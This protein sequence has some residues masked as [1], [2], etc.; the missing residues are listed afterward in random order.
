MVTGSDAEARLWVLAT[1][2]LARRTER[3]PRRGRVMSSVLRPA[4]AQWGAFVSVDESHAFRR[5]DLDSGAYLGEVP[6]QVEPGAW[7]MAAD[8]TLTRGIFGQGYENMNGRPVLVS[9]ED[10]AP[11][12]VLTDSW[13]GTATFLSDGR[14]VSGTVEWAVY[15]WDPEGRNPEPLVPP[16]PPTEQSETGP[17]P[18]RIHQ[19]VPCAGPPLFAVHYW[20]LISIFDG[21]GRLVREIRDHVTPSAFSR[22][23]K[24]FAS[25]ASSGGRLGVF[26]VAS[27]REVHAINADNRPIEVLAFSADNRRL[28]TADGSGDI[29]VRTLEGPDT[30]AIAFPPADTAN[31][32][33]MAR[34]LAADGRTLLLA[35]EG[36]EVFEW[37]LERRAAPVRIASMG[38]GSLVGTTVHVVE[39][40]VRVVHN[41]ASFMTLTRDGTLLAEGV[42]ADGSLECSPGGSRFAEITTNSV[43]HLDLATGR[44]L[45]EHR[46]APTPLPPLESQSYLPGRALSDGGRVACVDDSR[47][48][49]WE[50]DGRPVSA[51]P[52]ATLGLGP[53][54]YYRCLFLDEDQVAITSLQSGAVVTLSTGNVRAY[55]SGVATMLA[56]DPKRRRLLQSA[57]GE[58]GESI[59]VVRDADDS[60][61]V[62]EIPI[63]SS[64]CTAIFLDDG[65]LVTSHEDRRVIV[66]EIG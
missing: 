34:G 6:L 24:R 46:L 35:C 27:G 29:T 66:W 36:G 32:P 28:A 3:G 61:V 55:P 31:L 4:I 62:C 21:G 41:G 63:E 48:A 58:H 57:S 65:A 33:G 37:S 45:S 50:P 39:G 9:L 42:L 22:D 60:E 12:A 13:E 18:P 47:L 16:G 2:E 52:N 56:Y 59:L 38:R 25:H 64:L 10:G 17:L 14:I 23:G 51:I 11:L 20:D 53:A 43:V 49:V 15:V 1:G 30:V 19:I 5:W 8:A 26:D 54:P 7:M 44:V 40:N